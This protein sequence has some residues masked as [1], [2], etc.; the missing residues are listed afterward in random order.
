MVNCVASQE[1]QTEMVAQA[2]NS[3]TWEVE[4]GGLAV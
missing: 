2:C 3:Y 1:N 4:A